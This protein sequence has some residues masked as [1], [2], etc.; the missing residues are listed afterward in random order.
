[1]KTGTDYLL[2]MRMTSIIENGI[3]RPILVPLPEL[4][5]WHEHR[6]NKRWGILGQLLRLKDVTK[7]EPEWV[8]DWSRFELIELYKWWRR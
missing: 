6:R 8:Y 3:K 7:N 4:R 1:M 5:K 2:N